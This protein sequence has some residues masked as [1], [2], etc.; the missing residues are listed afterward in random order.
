MK[1]KLITLEGTEGSGKSLQTKYLKEHLK[2]LGLKVMVTREPGSSKIGKSIRRMLLD[3]KN[4]SLCDEAELFLY[5]ADRAQHVREIIKPYLEKGHIVICDRFMD[6]TLAY[7]GYGRK[8][9]LKLVREMN[10]LATGGIRPDLTIIFDIPVKIGLRRAAR[11]GP[12]KG[13]RIE[14]EKLKFHKDVRSGYMAIAKKEPKRVK[15]V[16][17]NAKPKDIHNK[18]KMILLQSR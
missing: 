12:W 5:L 17:V 7:Q 3:P 6:A 18:I 13:D 10:K 14:R 11:V 9:P 4:K 15:V 16:K 8:L 2:N 1:G